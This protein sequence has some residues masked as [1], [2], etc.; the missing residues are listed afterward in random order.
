MIEQTRF[1]VTTR[2]KIQENIDQEVI[3][4]CDIIICSDTHELIYVNPDLTYFAI[5][6]AEEGLTEL[7][8]QVENRLNEIQ[9]IAENSVV[10]GVKGSG[11][12]TYRKGNVNLG[13]SD[14]GL[15]NVS[16]HTQVRGNAAGTTENHLVS[17]GA[18]GYIVKDANI[19]TIG[20]AADGYGLRM[21]KVVLNSTTRNST[22]RFALTVDDSGQLNVSEAL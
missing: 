11:E 4:A 20:S 2:D 13:T 12:T 7:V 18:N 1:F 8:Q 17:W 15:G 5:V 14:I 22:K 3:N 9:S 10:T 21:D 19:S 6:A 16:N